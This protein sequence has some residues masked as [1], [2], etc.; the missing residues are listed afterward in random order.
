L[1][2]GAEL[3]TESQSLP[4]EPVALVDALLAEAIRRRASDLHVQP[5]SD[6]GRIRFRVDGLLQDRARV[7]PP[8]GKAAVNRLKV[9]AALLS[10]RTDVPQEGRIDLGDPDT[11]VR[12][13]RVSTFPTIH[14]EQAV[15]RILYDNPALGDLDRLGLPDH[16]AAA[17]DGI[18]R[19]SQGMLMLTGPAG[20]GKSTTLCAMLRRIL[21]LRPGA[22]VMSLE[23]PVER[24]I[25]G[26]SQV[27][28]RPGGE[29]TFPVALRSLLRQDPEVLMIGEIRDAET[30]R[31]AV[32]AALT[33]HL[34]LT[35]LHSG[36]CAGALLRLV[37][38]GVEAYQVSSSVL[39]VVN[40]RLVRTLCEHCSR[41]PAGPGR[42]V[43]CD[44]CL[45]TGYLG[46]AAMAEMATMSPE[47]GRQ[48]RR[49][50]DVR[51]LQDVL[52]RAGQRALGRHGLA[53]VESGRTTG[54][55]LDRVCAS[56]GTFG[57]GDG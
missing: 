10:Y 35:T 39:G 1:D 50:A 57:Q 17:L 34:L 23:D 31:I 49:D 36:S 4:A 51:G 54:E 45:Q 44:R 40:Q 29:M 6:A 3:S 11:G 38:M 18:C 8:L 28:I 52:N 48:L 2:V 21:T 37:E 30:A 41:S 26:V 15:V 24:R 33:G 56:G 16:V 25:D 27:Q 13:V 46:R 22:A 32:G 5:V 20:S 9:L 19:A 55:E 47:L 43:G 42:A 7:A 14:G 12:D 53:L